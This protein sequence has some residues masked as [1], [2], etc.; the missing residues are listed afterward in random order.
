MEAHIKVV[1]GKMDGWGLGFSYSGD[2]L[3]F[4]FIRWYLIVVWHK[5]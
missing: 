5:S 3:N 4:D 2:C 1:T